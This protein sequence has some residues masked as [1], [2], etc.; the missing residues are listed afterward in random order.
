MLNSIKAEIK[1]RYYDPGFRGL[2]LDE[3]FQ[4]A[5][6]KIKGATSISQIF[7]IIGQ[8]VADLDDSHTRFI[9]PVRASR[10]DYGWQ[11]QMIGQKCYVIAVR[12]GSD[13]EAKGLRVGDQIFSIN[14]YEPTRDNLWKMQYAYYTLRPQTSIELVVQSP[15]GESRQLEVAS[16]VNIGKMLLRWDLDIYDL[17]RESEGEAR[18]HRHR[19]YSESADVFIWKMPQFNLSDREVDDVMGRVARSK[20]LILDLRGNGGGYV[21]TLERMIGN[22][23]DQD[24]KIGDMKRRN[25]TKPWIAKTRGDK[26]FKGQLIVLVDSRSASASEIFARVVQLEKRGRVIGDRTAGAVMVSRVYPHHTGVDQVAYYGVSVTDADILMTDGQ[27]LEHVG[28][29]PDQ[30][31]LPSAANLA[32]QRDPVLFRAATLAG[33]NIEPEKIGALFP[34]EWGK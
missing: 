16:K 22:V 28:I 6:E 32:A 33:L 20:A 7:G 8:T 31:L 4:E 21:T 34:I 24:I 29:T 9:P 27:S 14:K 11:M 15:G 18:L 10:T 12:P 17:I 19:Y 13:A 5:E 3:R 25:E 26:T 2:D 23:F 30:L 1:S